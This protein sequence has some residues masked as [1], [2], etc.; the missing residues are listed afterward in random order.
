[1]YENVTGYFTTLLEPCH[2]KSLLYF[3]FIFFLLLHSLLFWFY[4]FLMEF[5]F[6]CTINAFIH[7]PQSLKTTKMISR[8]QCLRFMNTRNKKAWDLHSLLTSG[9]WLSNFTDLKQSIQDFVILVLMFRFILLAQF[10]DLKSIRFGLI[11][12]HEVIL[13]L[14]VLHCS[15]KY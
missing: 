14:Y 10:W 1:M 7:F 5:C 12:G 4:P 2:L 6:I 11:V 8:W 15:K 9:L 3:G 13:L